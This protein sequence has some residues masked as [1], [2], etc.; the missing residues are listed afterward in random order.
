MRASLCFASLL[1]LGSVLAATPSLAAGPLDNQYTMLMGKGPSGSMEVKVDADGTRH[2][3]FQFND[4]GRGP[5]TLSDI[6]FD[7]KGD[8][9]ALAITGNDYM[10]APVDEHFAADGDKLTWTSKA[11]SGSVAARANLLYAPFEGNSEDLAI[12]ARALLAA[13]DQTLDLLPGGR[14]HLEKVGTTAQACGGECAPGVAAASLYLI[15]GLGFE[16][17]PVWLDDATHEL[18][19][20]GSSWSSMVVK[21]DE[22]IAPKLVD[23]QSKLM[24]KRS[25]DDAKQMQDRTGNPV[26]IEHATLFDTVTRKLIANTTVRV[27]SGKVVAVGPDGTVKASPIDRV[28]DAH[29]QVLMP[30]LTDMHVHLGG[31]T[32][33][34]L[35]I[36]NGVTTVRD[37]GNDLDDLDRWESEFNSGEQIGPRIWKACLIDGRNPLAGPTKLLISTP[38]EAHAVVKTCWDHGFRQMKIYSSVDPKLVPVIIA[39]AHGR[40]MRVSGHIPAGMTMEQAVEDGYDEVQHA[41]FWFLNFRPADIV[42]KTNG[43]TRLKDPEEHARDLDL[44]S[45]QV[46]RFVALLQA[47][48]TVVDPT[49]V[50][51]EDDMVGVPHQPAPELAADASRLPPQVARG[52]MSSG[53]SDPEQRKTYAESYQRFIEFTGRLHKAGIR[54]VG[55]T[56][57]MA[58]FPLVHEFETYVAAGLPADEVLQLATLG[59]AQVMHHDDLAGSVAPGKNADLILID[60]NPVANISDLRKVTFVMKDGVIYDLPAIERSVGVKPLPDQ[61]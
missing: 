31:E 45:P 29:G 2:V 11:D 8:M 34:K 1:V 41:N 42:A 43:I 24:A 16:P 54:I 51:F 22:A 21:G 26:L 18:L 15:T 23:F 7:A 6:R 47:H 36:I 35:D 53:P 52:A 3:A 38:E 17:T 37:M 19:F 59:D 60:G 30:G 57:G 32:D 56:D 46:E 40:G 55:G 13:P 48:H 61:H 58:G 5:N 9:T 49:L 10:K 50:A 27:E 28:I 4:R 33:G 14:A 39:D 44:D 20:E 12:G 25:A